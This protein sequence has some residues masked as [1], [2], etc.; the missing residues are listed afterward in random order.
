MISNQILSISG[1]CKALLIGGALMLAGS[2]LHSQ[3]YTLEHAVQTALMNNQQVHLDKL[4]VASAQLKV[5]EAKSAN[6]PKVDLVNQYQ[7]YLDLPAQYAPA[8]AFGGPEGEYNKMTMNVE[9]TMSSSIQVTQNIINR[10]AKAKVESAKLSM[11]IAKLQTGLTREDLVY[12]VTATYFTIQVLEDNLKRLAD[13]IA[14]LEQT[15]SIN[16]VLVKNEM[17]PQ[18]VH[19]RLLINLENLQN[20]YENQALSI[21]KNYT[22]LKYLMNMNVEDSLSV[23]AFDQNQY[24][25]GNITVDLSNRIDIKVQ[26][27]QITL[28]QQ[29]LKTIKARY[30]PVMTASFSSGFT[31]YNDQLAPYEQ[32]NDDWIGH[33]YVAMNVRI[34]LFAGFQKKI[35][36]GAQKVNIQKSTTT[37]SMLELNATKEVRDAEQHCTTHRNQLMNTT[38]SLDLAQQLFDSSQNDYANGL[39]TVTDLLN[40]QN[41][42]TSARTN[43]STALLQVMLA[44]LSLK[45]AYGIL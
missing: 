26:R 4:N 38:K 25:S 29:E 45:K 15:V 40:A 2:R 43:Y 41:D 35:Q 37:L 18:N 27:A 44:E 7:Y 31:S 13:N 5:A 33:S 22:L 32:I 30:M 14:N 42:L 11:D 34:S 9:Q 36:L 20:E 23:T 12:N 10:E 8:S 21:E 16:E 19:N 39:I 17:V 1:A 3:T 6:L 28:A 24:I